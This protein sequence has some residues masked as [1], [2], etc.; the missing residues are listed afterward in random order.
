MCL[1]TFFNANVINLYEAHKREIPILS[2]FILR[3]VMESQKLF[4]H[5]YT[6]DFFFRSHFCVKVIAYYDISH[7][8]VNYCEFGIMADAILFFLET[9]VAICGPEGKAGEDILAG[10]D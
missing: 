1:I 10:S 6:F 8:Y 5:T 7:W 9:Q 3:C 4:S 2:R